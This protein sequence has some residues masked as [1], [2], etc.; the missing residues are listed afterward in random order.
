MEEQSLLLLYVL[1]M[2][3]QRHVHIL[4]VRGWQH[5]KSRHEQIRQLS[6]FSSQ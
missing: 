2:S 5:Q 6:V 3:W 4:Q 1:G